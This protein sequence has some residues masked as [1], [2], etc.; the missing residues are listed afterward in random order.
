MR[1]IENHCCDCAVPAY[2][3]MGSQCP[4]RNV[5]VIYC[6]ECTSEIER[7]EVMYYKNKEVCEECYDELTKKEV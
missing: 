7:N 5:E 2:P 3:C 4:Y 6:D 1:R